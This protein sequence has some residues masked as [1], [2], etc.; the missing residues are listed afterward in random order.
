LFILTLKKSRH[1]QTAK[2]STKITLFHILV[3][4]LMRCWK[5]KHDIGHACEN[6]SQVTSCGDVNGNGSHSGTVCV[7]LNMRR[8]G[9]VGAGA[10]LVRGFEVSKYYS[11]S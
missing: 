4:E 3:L 1:S 5:R 11:Y 10:S 7:T 2:V 8:Y 9:I 6:Q